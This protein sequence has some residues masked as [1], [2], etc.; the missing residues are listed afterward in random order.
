MDQPQQPLHRPQRLDLRRP[1]RGHLPRHRGPVGRAG[2]HLLRLDRPRVGLHLGAAAPAGGSRPSSPRTGTPRRRCRRPRWRW[3]RT[4]PFF[5]GKRLHAETRIELFTQATDTRP[6]ELKNQGVRP[7]VFF[8][9]RWITSI[10]DLFEENVRYFPA[11]LA[12]TTDEDPMAVAR[13]R[14]RPAAGRAAAA[15]RHRLPVEPAD[16]RHRRRHARTCGSRTACCRPARPSSTC[17]P[18]PPS[19]T[20]RSGC[21]PTRTA[22]CGPR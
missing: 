21:W 18:T 7:R 16:L 3:P 19:T 9:E 17:S 8:G 22:R 4:R 12:E 5:F 6:V 14:G 10:F 2:R 11:L 20:A 1:R 15:Q 13:G